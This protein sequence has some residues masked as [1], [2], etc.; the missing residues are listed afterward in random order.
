[1]KNLAKL[2]NLCQFLVIL[3]HWNVSFLS[4]SLPNVNVT[5]LH[6]VDLELA[7]AVSRYVGL[8]K[9]NILELEDIADQ[10][11]QSLSS[12]HK[13]GTRSYLGNPIAAVSIVKRFAEGWGKLNN[14]IIEEEPTTGTS[15]HCWFF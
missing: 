2:Y 11:K 4:A 5:E 14:F 13:Y 3:I 8:M 12:Q 10:A 7:R 9:E 15:N 1:M 6:F